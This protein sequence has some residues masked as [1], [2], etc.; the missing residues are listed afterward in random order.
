M[1]RH[2][3]GTRVQPAWVNR[4]VTQEFGTGVLTMATQVG[5][6][7][8]GV[9]LHQMEFQAGDTDLP[10]STA[11]VGSAGAGMVSSAVHAA[12]TARLDLPEPPWFFDRALPDSR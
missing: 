6:D 4:P 5:A 12:G 7:A 1:R 3:E 2:D 8:L 11:A 10:N 9:A